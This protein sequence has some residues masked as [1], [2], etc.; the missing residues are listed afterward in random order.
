MDRTVQDGS[1]W[2]LL[3]KSWL[4]DWEKYCFFDLIIQDPGSVSNE[5]ASEEERNS[6]GKINYSDIL[7]DISDNQENFLK[8]ISGKFTWH[9]HQLKEN[10]SEGQDYLLVDLPIIEYVDKKYGV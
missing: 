7:E 6:P 8:E 9:N 4:Q 3:P 10:V 1:Q 2:F 5:D